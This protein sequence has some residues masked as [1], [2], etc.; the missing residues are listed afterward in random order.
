MG[1]EGRIGSLGALV[2]LGSPLTALIGRS[3]I[4]FRLDPLHEGLAR[5]LLGLFPLDVI[6][7]IL[8]KLVSKL[9]IKDSY[10]PRR[11]SVWVCS[12]VTRAPQ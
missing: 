1:H 6:S 4:L 3:R 9:P 12:V 8:T 10:R 5:R 11:T 2:A 7:E